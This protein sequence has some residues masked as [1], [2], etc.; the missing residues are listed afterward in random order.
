MDGERGLRRD[1]GVRRSSR[2]RLLPPEAFQH[3]RDDR[4]KDAPTVKMVSRSPPPQK[5][6]RSRERSA[7]RKRLQDNSFDKSHQNLEQELR[8]NVD[9]QQGFELVNERGKE[10]AD[11]IDERV[12]NQDMSGA[13][14][15]ENVEVP[16]K[17]DEGE[18]EVFSDFGESDEE[19]LTKEGVHD[20]DNEVLD[21]S[22]DTR[23]TNRPESRTSSQK[24]APCKE[25]T[26]VLDI[27]GDLDEVSPG[28]DEDEIEK[29][30]DALDVDWSELM[31]KPEGF[32][33]KV[34]ETGVLKK[35][36]SLAA[37]L[38]RV[39]LSE[40]LVG[41]KKYDEI[42]ALANKDVDGR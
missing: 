5:R 27:S 2:E 34:E 24:S 42:I 7:E 26:D 9:E 18:E 38:N 36:W 16:I 23:T 13:D 17:A 14:A 12:S 25:N 29:T 22:G 37:I 6:V 11:K 19:I 30:K 3:N 40:S 10:P 8:P 35:R 28:E 15:G 32:V 33:V 20:I 4:K 39:G 21:R 41:K 31:G 1:R